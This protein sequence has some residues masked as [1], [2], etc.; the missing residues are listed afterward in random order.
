MGALNPPHTHTH[1]TH[2]SLQKSHA[3]VFSFLF[4]QL[5]HSHTTVTVGH[6]SCMN[7]N[8]KI[9][10]NRSAS[11]MLTLSSFIQSA[12]SV[13]FIQT[14]CRHF[15]VKG[16]VAS[17]KRYAVLTALTWGK[18]GLVGRFLLT[19]GVRHSSPLYIE[20]QLTFQKEEVTRLTTDQAF[21]F[22]EKVS[23]PLP[24]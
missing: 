17:I 22:D 14:N 6:V 15:K 11:C 20:S 18:G 13:P 19:P 23:I 16:V 24:L 8:L 10:F 1:P 2:W 3:F 9:R 5:F 12:N 4:C 7:L 21:Y